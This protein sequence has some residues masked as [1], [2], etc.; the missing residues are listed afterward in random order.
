MPKKR[1]RPVTARR[2]GRRNVR[3][4]IGRIERSRSW[5]AKYCEF[6]QYIYR[7]CNWLTHRPTDLLSQRYVQ[8][9]PA[10]FSNELNTKLKVQKDFLTRDF[11][12][13][14]DSFI[15]L[16]F[17]FK[18]LAKKKS[19]KLWHRKIHRMLRPSGQLYVHRQ[20]SGKNRRL[21]SIFDSCWRNEVS[22]FRLR[23]FEPFC[24]LYG[25]D[26]DVNTKNSLDNPNETMQKV[27]G[28]IV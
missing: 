12:S 16:W 27:L 20:W 5:L 9:L 10:G 2:E 4:I 25:A 26:V 15:W 8:L 14:K 21:P 22:N 6:D 13:R 19:D 7:G 11:V 18:I 24:E 3:R 23:K 1:G 17:N 28:S